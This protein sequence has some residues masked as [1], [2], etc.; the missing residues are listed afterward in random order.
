LIFGEHSAC[1]LMSAFLS[2][3][4]SDQ[5][6]TQSFANPYRPFPIF[7]SPTGPDG[8]WPP[9]P[10]TPLGGGGFGWYPEGKGLGGVPRGEPFTPWGGYAVEG[11][12]AD[13]VRYFPYTQRQPLGGKPLRG[14][15]KTHTFSFVIL[16]THELLRFLSGMA[17]SKPTLGFISSDGSWAFPLDFIFRLPLKLGLGLRLALG[18]GHLPPTH[19]PW[20]V[21]ARG[22]RDRGL[23]TWD[24]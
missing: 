2:H 22:I 20:R 24:H 15:P 9:I 7:F 5:S 11:L 13:L 19:P 4:M 1:L 18:L 23:Q 8:I 12:L 6:A 21:P 17:A 14:L 10:P 16:S 3:I